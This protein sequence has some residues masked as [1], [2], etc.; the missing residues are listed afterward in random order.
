M[1]DDPPITEKP[2]ETLEHPP[3]PTPLPRI[4][5]P[6]TNWAGTLPTRPV[7]WLAWFRATPR[8]EV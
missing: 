6:A 5:T 7:R 1:V 8:T 3:V 4:A 2:A